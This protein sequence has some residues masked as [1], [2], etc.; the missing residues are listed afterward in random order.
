MAR[1]AA[2]CHSPTMQRRRST[3]A[4]GIFIFA[5]LMAGAV[6]GIGRGEPTLWMLRG[7]GVGIALAILAWVIDRLRD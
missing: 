6:Y 2:I 7:F 5:G 4:G 3:A 1:R